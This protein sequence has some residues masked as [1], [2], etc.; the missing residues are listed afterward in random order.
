MTLQEL[1]K[2]LQQSNSNEAFIIALDP[3]ARAQD[4]DVWNL[5]G[6]ISMGRQP[7]S[8]LLDHQPLGAVRRALI[9]QAT[10][11][12]ASQ[13]MVFFAI[14][15]MDQREGRTLGA[16]DRDVWNLTHP[17]PAQSL[18]GVAL[19]NGDG[20][21]PSDSGPEV[22]GRWLLSVPVVEPSPGPAQ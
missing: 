12:A 2:R 9:F 17:T 22:A 21:V 16:Q 19:E 1:I 3:G 5:T 20:L 8:L 13:Q 18:I 11:H 14:H 6:P 7:D 15:D 10:H 4:R